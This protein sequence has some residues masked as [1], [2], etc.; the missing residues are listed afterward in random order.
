VE[1]IAIHSWPANMND[2][3]RLAACL[4][5]P[6][7]KLEIHAFP[8]GEIRV[9]AWP[10][11]T[12]GVIYASL[13]L[14]NDKLLALLFAAES[15][16]RNGSRRLVL[17][18]PY[19]CYMRQDA[20]FHRGESI[21]QK[22]IGK[23]ISDCFDRVVTVDAHLHRTARLSDVCPGIQCDNLSAMAAIAKYLGSASL[24]RATV[25]VGPDAESRQ[26][27][28]ELSKLLGVSYVVGR[29]LRQGESLG[30][31]YTRRSRGSRGPASSHCR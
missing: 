2:A 3:G 26:W 10:A 12:V 22:V 16:R 13:D 18:A 4:G 27:V 9:S 5:V 1:D 30:K 14:P 7:H 25:I 6:L 20:A 19:L 24:D 8:D 28:S 29:K 17:V 15:L 31:D 23:L 21:S 11:S